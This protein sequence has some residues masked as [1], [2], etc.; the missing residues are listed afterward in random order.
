MG[1]RYTEKEVDKVIK[2]TLRIIDKFK[3]QLLEEYGS[4]VPNMLDI[5]YQEQCE[6]MPL[7]WYEYG[8]EFKE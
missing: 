4:N 2:V 8:C 1:K 3:S 5:L 6:K 7:M